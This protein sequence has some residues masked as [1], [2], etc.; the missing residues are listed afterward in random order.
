MRGTCLARSAGMEPTAVVTNPNYAVPQGQQSVCT[1][2]GEKLVTHLAL[3]VARTEPK[4]CRDCSV[5]DLPH[6]D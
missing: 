4:L 1:Q 6:T 5:I 3:P 2:C